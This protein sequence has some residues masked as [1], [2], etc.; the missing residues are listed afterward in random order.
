MKI[1]NLLLE[2][3]EFSNYM[4]NNYEDSYDFLKYYFDINEIDDFVINNLQIFQVENDLN[5]TYNNI[6][7][8]SRCYTESLLYTALQKS[9]SFMNRMGMMKGMGINLG[10]IMGAGAVGSAIGGEKVDELVSLSAET[11]LG[12]VDASAA[13]IG[14]GGSLAAGAA[15]G[16]GA[17]GGM[18]VVGTVLSGGFLGWNIGTLFNKVPG[19]SQS[20]GWVMDHGLGKGIE[21]AVNFPKLAMSWFGNAP[22]KV[23]ENA[24]L[25]NV[26]GVVNSAS[27]SKG[28]ENNRFFESGI[29]TGFIKYVGSKFELIGSEV[30]LVWNNLLTIAQNQPQYLYGPILLLGVI[31]IIIKYKL[32][33]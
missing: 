16:I 6:K 12:V 15:T 31:G 5:A 7:I 30:S 2:N 25:N 4:D 17:A 20:A 9:G 13:L 27:N 32:K 8:F 26:H 21:S 14:S 33:H 11:G 23:V 3:Q 29:F 1:L 10:G 18:A 24:K 22:L 28:L 19:V